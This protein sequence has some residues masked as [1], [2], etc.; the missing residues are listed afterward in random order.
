MTVSKEQL[1]SEIIKKYNRVHFQNENNSWFIFMNDGYM[2]LNNGYPVEGNYP[3]LTELHSRWRY[4]SYLY[5]QLLKESG[6][7]L[8]SNLGDILD[9]GCGRGGGLSVFR[10]YYK[11]SSLTGLDLNPNQIKF[12]SDTHSNIKFVQGSAMELPFEPESFDI[13]TNVESANYYVYYDEFLECVKRVLKNNGIFLYA[14]TFDAER[15]YW[16]EKSLDLHGFKI[17][18]K[19]NI[20]ENV[21]SACAIDKYR[22]LDY[23]KSLADVMMWDEERYY[24][25]R[26]QE[27]DHYT[28]D[29]YIMV[30]SKN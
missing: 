14:D 6:L 4:Q 16:V 15:M 17:Q 25:H 7:D 30:I 12:A 8:N 2:P 3:V 18:S 28:A 10:D 24:N 5:I 23:S 26:R 20:T 11:T 19:A 1:Y 9:I 22:L 27:N 29:Y 21:R 13:V